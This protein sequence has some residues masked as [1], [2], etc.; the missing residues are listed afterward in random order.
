MNEHKKI[1]RTILKHYPAAQAIYLF[2][3]HGTLYERE[4]SD[5]DIAIL[6]PPQE[7]KEVGSLVLSDLLFELEKS[8]KRNIDL[9]NL[10]QAP[11]V[12]Q[13]EIITADR[14]IYCADQYAADEFEMLIISY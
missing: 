7:A 6:L 11:T 3:S 13:K 10:R 14:R 2:G 12:L 5:V 1:T 8:L 4:N 9:T